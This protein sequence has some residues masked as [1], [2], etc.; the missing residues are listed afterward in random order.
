[1]RDPES[2]R[3]IIRI[4]VCVN[5]HAAAGQVREHGTGKSGR[6]MKTKRRDGLNVVP[7]VDKENTERVNVGLHEV[8]LIPYQSL[9][10][11]RGS[12]DKVA[13]WAG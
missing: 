7:V 8:N 3:V 4:P 11:G 1:M 2:K 5:E 6:H 12:Q 10:L 9:L 13:V